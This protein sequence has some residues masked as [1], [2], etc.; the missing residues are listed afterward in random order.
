MD[1]KTNGHAAESNGPEQFRQRS[2]VNAYQDFLRFRLTPSEHQTLLAWQ[3]RAILEN[4]EMIPRTPEERLLYPKLKQLRDEWLE[5]LK[6]D[7]C[8]E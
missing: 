8:Y 4:D 7:F 5:N 2:L 6:G 1:S 3:M